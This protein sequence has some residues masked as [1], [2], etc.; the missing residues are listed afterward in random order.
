M[1]R[2]SGVSPKDCFFPPPPRLPQVLPTLTRTLR[3]VPEVALTVL[4]ALA[5]GSTL[6]LSAASG[7]L[8]AIVIQQLRA[9]VWG[10]LLIF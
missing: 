7:E 8:L 5:R 6:D 3:R 9:K 4:T 10:L 2:V 1:I